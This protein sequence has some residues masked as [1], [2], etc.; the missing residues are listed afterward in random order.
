M[1]GSEVRDS[2]QLT[3][4]LEYGCPQGRAAYQLQDQSGLYFT[5]WHPR[6]CPS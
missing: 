6:A 2:S 4:V 5:P 3:S 1:L